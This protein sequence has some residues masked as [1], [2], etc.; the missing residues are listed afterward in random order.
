MAEAEA[1]DAAEPIANRVVGYHGDPHRQQVNKPPVQ[2]NPDK[3]NTDQHSDEPKSPSDREPATPTTASVKP[4]LL[5]LGLIASLGCNAFLLWVAT[6]QRSRYRALLRRMFD[7][8]AGR[9]PAAMLNHDVISPRWER[10]PEADK[11][12]TTGA[13]G[14]APM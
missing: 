3:S 10:L 14:S 13:S 6:G 5:Q 11:G 1:S 12:E 8:V 9:E 7:G 4:A 2:K